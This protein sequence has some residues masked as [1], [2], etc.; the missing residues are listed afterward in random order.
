MDG[1]L[2][3]LLATTD[4]PADVIVSIGDASYGDDPITRKSTTGESIYSCGCLVSYRSKRQPIIATSTHEAEI[5][6]L[7]LVANE[8]IWIRRLIEEL[9]ILGNIDVMSTGRLPPTPLLGDNKASTFTANTPSTGAMSKHIDI[10]YKKVREYVASGELRVVH[11]GT[12]YNVA[13]FFT[14][15]LAIGK[16]SRFRDFLMGE[17]LSEK[18]QK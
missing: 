13:D 16:F 12:D 10:R 11:V 5:V 15:G 3:T 1:A 18:K 9:G 17:Q 7:T 14:K 4:T 2:Q 8:T 6:A